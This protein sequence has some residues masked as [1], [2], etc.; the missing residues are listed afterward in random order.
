M[1]LKEPIRV[2]RTALRRLS[3]GQQ[4]TLAL[5]IYLTLLESDSR[6]ATV[7]IDDF[8]E[9]LDF[10]HAGLFTRFLLDRLPHSP[11]QF[12]VATNDRY[13]MNAVPLEHWTILVEQGTKTRVFNYANSRERFDNFKFTG[14]CNFDFFS[15]DFADGEA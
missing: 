12:I 4:R 11:L 8:A 3:Q 9:G 15:M 5:I 10:V 1:E 13:V 14:L 6:P 2:T 7:L